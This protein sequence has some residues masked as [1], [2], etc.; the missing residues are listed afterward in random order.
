MTLRS[1]LDALASRLANEVLAAIQGASLQ[2]L[3]ASGGGEIGSG[4]ARGVVADSGNGVGHVVRSTGK[5]V[6]L[7]RRSR[8][9]IAK[10]L[11]KVV[12]LVKTHR[13]GMRSEDIRSMLGM[14]ANE[15]PR[16]LREGLTA[17]KLTS[18][19]NKRATTYFAKV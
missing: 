2:E 9:E 15:M 13:D 17:N 14:Q 5:P 19:G 10:V 12:L 6:R 16:I 3:A 11:E 1:R 7:P 4:R 18:K 8:A